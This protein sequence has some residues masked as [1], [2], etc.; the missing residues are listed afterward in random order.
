MRESRDGSK[1]T[2]PTLAEMVDRRLARRSVL[3]GAAASV[4]VMVFGAALAQAPSAAGYIGESIG[5]TPIALSDEDT[6]LVPPGY[7]WKTLI[8]WGDPIFPEAPA[9]DLDEQTKERQEQQFGYNNDFVG[10]FPLP[11]YRYPVSDRGLLAVSHEYVKP[12]LMFPAYDSEN[13]T[14]EQVAVELAAHGA[15]VIEVFEEAGEW[16][17]SRRSAYNR[18]ITA[19]TEMALTGP[20][21]GHELL[22]TTADPT[23]ANVLGT[24]NN[25]SGGKT[26]WGT[27]LLAEENFQDYFGNADSID[28]GDPRRAVHER[29]GLPEEGSELG[30]ENFHDRF[31]LSKEPN[32]PFRF[33]WT[34]EVDPYDPDSTPKKHTALGRFR[35]EAATVVIAPNGKAVVYSGDDQR[36]DYM[37]KFISS[38]KFD[39]HDRAHNLT[40]L[41]EGDLYVAKLNENGSGSWLKLEAGKGFLAGWTAAEVLINTRGAADLLGATPMDRPE[42]IEMNPVT[43]KVYAVMT[44]NTKRAE[45]DTDAA[46]PRGPN[47][48][49]H[50]IEI[51]ERNDN[52]VGTTFTW[53]I[54]ILCGDPSNEDHHAY[55][56]GYDMTKVSPFANPDNVVF[57]A[58]GNLWIA[59]DG[60]PG[61]LGKN[62]GVFAVP[63]V[64]AER[65]Y[66]R[67]FVSAPSGAEICGPEFT[68]DNRAFFCAMQHPGEGGTIAEPTSTWPDNTSPAKPSLV[69][70]TKAGGSRVI[71]S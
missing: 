5:F 67:Q 48:F 37:Y 63:T 14:E 50:I 20:A 17:Y 30:W 27:A 29:Y 13:P 16:L 51:N 44:N 47:A 1:S 54:F 12:E 58:R 42:D 34:V 38:G 45:D 35:H 22:Q 9:L 64:G 32:E 21:A 26:P 24:L 40:L 23:G 46:N 59:T 43:G 65:G 53:D 10:F 31:D 28:A 61:R 49:G 7:S 25:C 52:P 33:G 71:G 19:E 8:R 3:A 41:E 11:D 56:A 6:V 2:S 55:Y 60:Q 18:R 70:I 69:V 62:D 57:D 36:F 4:P 39:P 15:T 66:A 68:P